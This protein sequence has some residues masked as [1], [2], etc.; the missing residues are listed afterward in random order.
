MKLKNKILIAL[1]PIATLSVVTPTLVACAKSKSYVIEYGQN[2][3]CIYKK[4]SPEEYGKYKSMKTIAKA[5][6]KNSTRAPK[7]EISVA[8]ANSLLT[9]DG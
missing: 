3:N 4:G 5:I 9:R 8:D 2:I 7:G 6:K 1:S